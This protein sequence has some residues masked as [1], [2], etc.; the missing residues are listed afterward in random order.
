MM[1]VGGG[2]SD[3]LR[4][5]VMGSSVT[6]AWRECV[7][8]KRYCLISRD[9]VVKTRDRTVLRGTKRHHIKGRIVATQ[10]RSGT[11]T[12]ILRLNGK[13]ISFTISHMMAAV[14]L[15]P[16]VPLRTT[17]RVAHLDS[18]QTNNEL[19]NLKI[20]PRSEAPQYRFSKAR[21]AKAALIP[22]QLPGEKWRTIPGSTTHQLSNLSRLLSTSMRPA[23][24][25]PQRT[26]SRGVAMY[27]LVQHGRVSNRS[28]RS[29]MTEVWPELTEHQPKKKRGADRGESD[30]TKRGRSGV[31]TATKTAPKR[32]QKA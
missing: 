21:A 5:T 23:M 20:V 2:Y 25:I 1:A 13:C 10:D 3:S 31:K 26:S 18:D 22:I 29:L 7:G 9:G 24:I 17:E 28:V 19:R 11:P 8:L 12:I 16:G 6:G 4:V 27:R 14:W 32:R 30:G 15:R